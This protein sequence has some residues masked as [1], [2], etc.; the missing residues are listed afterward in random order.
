MLKFLPTQGIPTLG[1]RDPTFAPIHKELVAILHIAASGIM[2]WGKWHFMCTGFESV[3]SF[4]I[5]YAFTF[6]GYEE[7][8]HL[9]GHY[10]Q[11]A[12]IPHLQTSSVFEQD[13]IELIEG[14]NHKHPLTVSGS[15]PL[16][17]PMAVNDKAIH[18][19]QTLFF[20]VSITK[21]S[22][23]RKSRLIFISKHEQPMK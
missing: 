17:L 20:V 1:Y 23:K 3:C 9:P 18:S 12:T 4:S 22:R 6:G 16:S 13:N 5:L 15:L 19:S 2:S 11:S 10:V 7:K 14:H 8:Q 21:M